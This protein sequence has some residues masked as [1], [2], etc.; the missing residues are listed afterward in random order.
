MRR[1]KRKERRKSGRKSRDKLMYRAAGLGIPRLG[2]SRTSRLK[3][4]FTSFAPPQ[5][6]AP[7]EAAK[8]RSRQLDLA[9][10]LIN[11]LQTVF[12]PDGVLRRTVQQTET[13]KLEEALNFGDTL[14][15]KME[16][17]LSIRSESEEVKAYLHLLSFYQLML[18]QFPS[19]DPMYASFTERTTQ[20]VEDIKGAITHRAEQ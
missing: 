8:A 7:S 2:R 18:E 5:G 11:E 3:P 16:A 13:Q 20:M 19:S 15:T 9:D 6:N 10:I 17:A 12:G 4:R 1:S 14:K